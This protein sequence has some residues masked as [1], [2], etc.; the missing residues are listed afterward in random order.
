MYEIWSQ[1]KPWIESGQAFA[2]AT[3][4]QARNP[5]PRGLGSVLAIAEFGDR[6]IGSVSA[7]CVESEVIEM[8]L[9]CMRDGKTRWAEFGPSQGFP[10]EVAFSCGG[11]IT[12]RVER[13]DYENRIVDGLRRLFDSRGK[14]LWIAA[15]G[16]QALLLDDGT[17]IGHA[18]D[19]AGE[20][21]QAG[22]DLLAAGG[23]TCELENGDGRVLLR[24]IQQPHRL[25]IVG[26][27]H[28][29][30]HLVTI[31][32]TLNYQ[33]IVIDPRESY[34][35]PERFETTPDQLIRAWPE[36]A[37]REFQLGRGDRAVLLTHDPKIDDQ[38][39]RVFLRTDC[40]YLGALGSRRSHEAR[41]KRL[42]GDGFDD[43][44]LTRIHGPVGLDIGSGAPAE[45][46]VSI[47][48]QII[49][50]KN[51]VRLKKPLR[52]VPVS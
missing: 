6:F 26:A 24:L 1:L 9:A 5:S 8:A 35:Q 46:A 33:T 42:A 25:F 22:R 18:A 13:F 10:W 19:W 31:A 14:G 17:V 39:L 28:I 27:V 52:D 51:A 15:E 44:T 7:G 45:I 41:L 48:A 2:L 12:V 50:E 21:I 3:V 38:A 30:I 36:K 43:K 49:Q 47:M 34:A 32:R 40:A 23:N 29:A 20:T 11:K 16:K 4:V 37:L